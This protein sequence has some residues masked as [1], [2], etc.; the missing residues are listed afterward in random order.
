[1][2]K[3]G[4]IQNFVIALFGIALVAMSVGFAAYATTLTIGGGEDGSTHSTATLSKAWDIHYDSTKTEAQMETAAVASTGTI[5][6][7][8]GTNVTFTAS[9]SQPGDYYQFTLPVINDG[10]MTAYLDSIVMSS[11]TTAQAKYIEFKIE[12]DGVTAT[13]TTQNI[14]GK[15]I[16]GGGTSKNMV[17]TVTYKTPEDQDDLPN[18]ETTVQLWAELLFEDTDNTAS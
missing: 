14:T 17:V 12:Y 18:A 1:M 8:T 6:N 13:S 7:I 16:A 10:S 9:L 3:E 2:R 15:S 4:R 11:L 5:T